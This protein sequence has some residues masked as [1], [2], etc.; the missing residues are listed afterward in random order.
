MKKKILIVKWFIPK[1]DFEFYQQ[2]ALVSNLEIYVTSDTLKKDQLNTDLTVEKN[3]HSLH[4]KNIEIGPFVFNTGLQKVIE[5][6]KPDVIVFGSNPRDISLPFRLMLNKYIYRYKVVTWSM[7]HRIGGPK[8]F[9]T[10][11]IKFIGRIS[12]RSMTYTDIGANYLI[13]RGIPSEKIDVIG[14]AIDEKQVFKIQEDV[15]EAAKKSLLDEYNLKGKFVL[16]QVMRLSA[17]KNPFLLVD[18]MKLLVRDES[19]TRL[20][21]IGGGELEEELKLYVKAN[22]LES[23]FIFLG[24]MYDEIELAKWFDIA[25][26]FVIPTC[27]GLSAHHA[28]CYGLPVVTDNSKNNQASEFDILKDKHNCLIYE[29][30]DMN[31]FSEKIIQLKQDQ[32]LYKKL[33]KNALKTVKE[34]HT[35]GR[36]VDNF[37]S[38]IDR[39][40]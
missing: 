5:K 9:S 25:Q 21:L 19:N 33:S 22:N 24:P 28:F 20:V 36:K 35:L 34:E 29:E 1:Y 40:F 10:L 18:M 7:Y 37:I 26:V 4:V 16:L 39:N 3:F 32:N 31:S 8:L 12:D 11:M 6:I 14:T 23:H 2:L 13:E 15:R 17:I 30:G 38:S 27:I